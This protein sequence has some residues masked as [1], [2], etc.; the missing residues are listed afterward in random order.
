M[1]LKVDPGTLLA[2]WPD[3]M[4]PNFMHS[5][6]LLCNH[7]AEGA[8]GLVVNR[9][10]GVTTDKLLPEHPLLNRLRLPVHLGGPVDHSTLHLV[11]TLPEQIPG[12][13]PICGEL[14][15]GGDLDALGK[16]IDDGRDKDELLARVRLFLGYSGWAAGQ[17]ETELSVGSW[18]PAPFSSEAIFASDPQLVW[19]NV[20]R[21]VRTELPWLE[22]M[23]PDVT[24]N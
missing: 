3:L 17:L 11:H 13:L 15:L 23:P 10:M 14:T 8:F 2:A 7:Q 21:S 9:P 6:V 5:V 24:W 22:D 1:E 18:V 19:R 20:V 4:D 16:M 12:G